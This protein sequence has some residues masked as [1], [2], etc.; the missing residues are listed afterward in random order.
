MGIREV[1][2][3]LPGP[4]EMKVLLTGKNMQD[5]CCS[6]FNIECTLL[7][8]AFPSAVF[9]NGL[10]STPQ[11][12][13]V[14]RKFPDVLD[15]LK[16]NKTGKMDVS[17][18]FVDVGGQNNEKRGTATETMKTRATPNDNED[19]MVMEGSSYSNLAEAERVIAIVETVL[20]D[21]DSSIVPK[22]IGIVTPYSA[23]VALIRSLLLSSSKIQQYSKLTGLETSALIAVKSVDGYQGRERDIIIF[24]TVRSNRS[25]KIGFLSDW[26]RM[27]VSL[28]RARRGLVVVGDAG[29]L[30]RAGDGVW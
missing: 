13:G 5:R 15:C 24:S 20:L 29:T 9:Y 4:V 19:S 16:S 17:V 30:S 27:N 26:R 10:L 14:S 8:S 25:G 21:P 3:K 2:L 7:S 6:P 22:D 28:T 23:Q 12:L 1:P 18:R 11:E